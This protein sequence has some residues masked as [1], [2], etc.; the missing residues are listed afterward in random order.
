MRMKLTICAALPLSLLAIAA[1]DPNALAEKAHQAQASR[2][3]DKAIRILA[4]ADAAW[5]SSSPNVPEHAEAL[6]LM[7][8]LMKSQ[9]HAAVETRGETGSEAGLEQWRTEAA[10]VVK[11]AIEICEANCNAKPEDLALALE[12]QA[13][14]LGRTNEG[15]PFWDRAMK[16][17]AQRVAEISAAPPDQSIDPLNALLGP[18]PKRVGGDVSAPSILSKKEPD[19][20]ET[21]QLSHYSGTALFTVIIDAQGIPTNIRLVRGL[22][23]GLDENGAQ[24]ISVWRFRPA[25]KEGSPVA[26]QVNIEV[27]FR[28]L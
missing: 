17:R 18:P 3:Y 26:V 12:L 25:T 7:A 28:L 21:A 9:A 10:P 19:Y 20:T 6:E 22:G 16:I 1:D 27:N 24:A 14:I 4:K 11:R 23:Y 5:E 8:L 13:D 15:A 2:D